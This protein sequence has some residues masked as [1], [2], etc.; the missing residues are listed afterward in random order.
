MEHQYKLTTYLSFLIFFLFTVELLPINFFITEERDW[1]AYV[2]YVKDGK[3]PVLK[4][5]NEDADTV[6]FIYYRDKVLIVDEEWAKFGWKKVVYPLNGFIEEKFLITPSEKEELDEKFNY[7]TPENEYSKWEW[8]IIECSIQ[9]AFVKEKT[10]NAS[11]TV[12]LLK[13][14]EKI[15]VVKDQLNFPGI[16]RKSVYPYS[17]F[18]NYFDITTGGNIPY[19]SVGISYGAYHLP[20]EKNLK[21]Y[22][23]PLGGYLEYS[24]TNWDLGFR[25]GY[26]Y[27]ES[28]LTTNYLKTNQV[29]F[30]IV[31]KF[32]S[33]FNSKL[34]AYLLAGGNYWFSNF[35]NIK[36]GTDNSYFK[37]EKASGIGYA[38]GGGLI[39]NLSNFFIEAQYVFFGSK[40]A[41]FGRKPVEG[42]FRSYNTLYPG[43]NRLEII[44]GY[45]FVL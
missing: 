1:T 31:Y 45:R 42:E 43:S 5:T 32:F 6:G 26:D 22:F 35:Q 3:V 13:E 39:Y 36:Y 33:I 37:L 11:Q 18:I 44:L 9:Y 19:I 40:E 29:Y 30:H 27:T 21:N 41:E 38:A 2:L 7:L 16:W 28:R 34:E 4:N 20:Y 24:K 10:D 15:L 14:G 23:N 12:G 25:L 8:E 17:G